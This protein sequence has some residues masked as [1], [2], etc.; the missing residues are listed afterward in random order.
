MS[1]A[2]FVDT[3]RVRRSF[4][5]VADRYG[6]GDFFAREIDRRM[7]ERLDYVRLAPQRILDLGC[8]RGAS[9]AALRGRYPEAR[10]VGVDGVEA[11]LPRQAASP[12]WRRWWPAAGAASPTFVA[13]D[14]ARLPFAA[15]RFGLVW[16]NLLLH[17]LDDPLPALAEGHRVL[18]TGGLLMFSTLGPDTLR[19]LRECFADGHGH[20]QRTIDMHDL[21][22]M[23]VSCGFADP[24]MD[25]EV[26]TLTYDS[27]AALGRD[28]RAAGS[29]CAMGDRRRGLMGRA[30]WAA[31]NAAYETRRREGKLPATFEVVYGHAWKAA[32]K[33]TADGRSI[34][35][36]AA[37]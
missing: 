30:S 21:G 2:G 34:I 12:L 14:A 11:M 4:A 10:G 7:L 9:L 18:E 26:I 29:T 27:L 36:F 1:G 6:E 15:D 5:Q 25:M 20:V 8:S 16:S 28:L 31:L 19:E 33:K 22:D 35:R 23:L 3:A 24:V 17:W 13:A 32:P 37:R